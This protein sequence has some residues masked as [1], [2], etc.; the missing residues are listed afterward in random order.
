MSKIARNQT[1]HYYGP[2]RGLRGEPARVMSVHDDG[3]HGITVTIEF[4][5]V[6]DA[7]KDPMV[8]MRLWSVSPNELRTANEHLACQVAE[9]IIGSFSAK[10]NKVLRSR[11]GNRIEGLFEVEDK[12]FENV[13]SDG[14]TLGTLEFLGV[15]G[16]GSK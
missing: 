1:V 5:N 11:R 7:D 8:P 15:L 16:K 6:N 4:F 13:L 2:A 14:A 3:K 9:T 12:S 10:L